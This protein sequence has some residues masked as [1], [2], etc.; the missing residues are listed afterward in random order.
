MAEVI[1]RR[2]IRGAEGPSSDP[3][4]TRAQVG[5]DMEICASSEGGSAPPSD[6]DG[7]TPGGRP[8]RPAAEVRRTVVPFR[9]TH[10]LLLIHTA[11]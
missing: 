11:A 4:I 5:Q 1:D 7:T 8:G 10:S 6:G 3:L 9:L 2:Q